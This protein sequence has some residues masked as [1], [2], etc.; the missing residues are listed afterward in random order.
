MRQMYAK[1]NVSSE[2]YIIF[3]F[4]YRRGDASTL[5]SCPF[6]NE[7]AEKTLIVESPVDT[8]SE[9]SMI[10]PVLNF[11]LYLEKIAQRAFSY[12]DRL[13]VAG[14]WSKRRLM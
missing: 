14:S 9:I 7:Q 5:T 8:K 2:I 11:K 1:G 12:D 6:L 13:Y 4:I 10:I 3:C